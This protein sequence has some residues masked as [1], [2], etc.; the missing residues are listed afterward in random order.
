MDAQMLVLSTNLSCAAV[1]QL[2]GM[3]VEQPVSRVVRFHHLLTLC[4]VGA[5]AVTGRY[6]AAQPCELQVQMPPL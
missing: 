6:A 1:A 4:K 2:T 3:G 5:S